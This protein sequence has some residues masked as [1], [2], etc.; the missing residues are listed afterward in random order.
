VIQ[1]DE[2]AFNVYMD[3]V[4]D[5]HRGTGG[6]GGPEQERRPHIHGHGIKANVD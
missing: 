6:C 2:P 3:E 1:F 4:K 5:Q